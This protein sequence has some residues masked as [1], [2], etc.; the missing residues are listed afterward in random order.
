M[1]H[2]VLLLTFFTFIP[3]L[4]AKEDTSQERP[5]T[6]AVHRTERLPYGDKPEGREDQRLVQGAGDHKGKP[7]RR[8]SIQ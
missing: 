4:N 5:K 1:K 8:C 7:K 6:P 2:I 3:P